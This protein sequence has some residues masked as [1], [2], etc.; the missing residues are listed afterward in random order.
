MVPSVVLGWLRHGESYRKRFQ[1]F[2]EKQQ[3]ITM[4]FL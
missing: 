2:E 1:I 3:I 4:E